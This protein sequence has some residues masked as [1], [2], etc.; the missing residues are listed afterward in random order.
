MN[1]AAALC[2][3]AASATPL[4]H[5]RTKQAIINYPDIPRKWTKADSTTEHRQRVVK[6]LYDI[7]TDTG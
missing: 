4:K 1:L 7:Y 2:T 6:I 5:F 3:K